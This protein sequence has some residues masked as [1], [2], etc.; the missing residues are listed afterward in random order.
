MVVIPPP[1]G[2]RSPPLLILRSGSCFRPCGWSLPG[3]RGSSFHPPAPS[4]SFLSAPP[5][6]VP[7]ARG[8]RR[9]ASERGARQGRRHAGVPAPPRSR[10]DTV[11]L[12]DSLCLALCGW[13]VNF[14][15]SSGRGERRRSLLMFSLFSGIDVCWHRL[16][17]SCVCVRVCVYV[18][19]CAWCVCVCVCICGGCECVCVSERERECVCECVCVCV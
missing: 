8:A 9:S 5:R 12:I 17:L 16:A 19:A 18:C 6:G 11:P 15:L 7:A 13:G 14:S 3:A 2:K 1:K 4:A 10:R